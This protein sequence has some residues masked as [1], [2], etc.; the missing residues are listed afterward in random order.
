MR[1]TPASVHVA[2]AVSKL[3][4]C[5]QHCFMCLMWTVKVR[6]HVYKW[7]T[8]SFKLRKW[9][10]FM[11]CEVL[12]ILLME[13]FASCF[14]HSSWDR[15]EDGGFCKSF[16]VFRLYLSGWCGCRGHDPK[17]GGRMGQYSGHSGM[18]ARVVGEY[19]GPQLRWKAFL[20]AQLLVPSTGYFTLRLRW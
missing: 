18:A 14:Q 8:A 4:F 13:P 2:A 11:H 12:E 1:H 15:I 9:M 10:I 16:R 5:M 19:R 6:L 3:V 20:C 7:H 17:Q